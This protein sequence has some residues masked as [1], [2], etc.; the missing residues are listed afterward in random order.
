VLIGMALTVLGTGSIALL[1]GT[2]TL[3]GIALGCFVVG[4]GLGL[5]A[6]PSLIGAQSSVGWGERGVV[7]GANLF[8]RSIGSA[9]GVAVF[10][11]IANAIFASSAGGQDDPAAVISASGAVFLAV[12]VCA[13]AT[14]VAG[15]L[16]PESR[17][18]DTEIARPQPVA[19]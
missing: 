18:E 8:A 14:V 5:V 19:D 11:A 15:L 1:A 4:L 16:M 12:G 9:V 10:G 3:V 2:P 13:L 7:T 6:T 17:V